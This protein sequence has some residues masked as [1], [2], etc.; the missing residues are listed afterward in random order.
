M[1]RL[2]AILAIVLA[3]V[4]AE[5]MEL[6]DLDNQGPSLNGVWQIRIFTVSSE[7]SDTWGEPYNGADQIEFIEADDGSLTGTMTIYGSTFP[8]T[9]RVDYGADRVI[10]TW[11]GEEKREGRT[12]QRSFH[13]FVLPKFAYSD[14]QVDTLA[15][16]EGM[17]E[18]G[19]T[20]GGSGSFIA[21]PMEF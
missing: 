12:L 13:A 6:F 1:L 14:E 18:A 11:S 2:L 17:T 8:I 21:V 3:P 20:F 4:T 16:T 19:A 15:G 9:G 7:G 5:A 10:V